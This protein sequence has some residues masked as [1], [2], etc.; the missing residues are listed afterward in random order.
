M[1]IVSS[2]AICCRDHAPI[3]DR[4]ALCETD[5]APVPVTVVTEYGTAR[6]QPA[7]P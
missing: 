4:A 6:S 7:A 1:F 2:G 5:A 3:P